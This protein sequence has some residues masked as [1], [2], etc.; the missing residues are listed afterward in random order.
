MKRLLLRL[1][2]IWIGAA[3]IF[4]L[5]GCLGGGRVYLGYETQDEIKTVTVTHPNQM[6]ITDRFWK[7][8]TPDSTKKEA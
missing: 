1:A 4:F 2:V 5:T 7:W 3:A 8:A 6:S